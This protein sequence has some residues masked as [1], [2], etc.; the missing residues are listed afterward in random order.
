M[1][2]NWRFVRLS[3]QKRALVFLLVILSFGSSYSL[4]FHGGGFLEFVTNDLLSSD[5][6][7]EDL[8]AVGFHRKLL[9]RFRN[10]YT[11][12]NSFKGRPVAQ[13]TPSSSSPRPI[14]S[15]KA[16]ASPPP[17][18]SP[19]AR[20]VSAPPPF[21]HPLNF[22]ILRKS[23]KPSSNNTVPIVAGCFGGA[24][25]IIL[26]ATGVFF[27]KTK[28][29]KS[30]N[31][32][33]TGLSGQLQKVFITG[34][35]KL[36]RSE[37]EAAC[38]DFSNVIGSCPIGTL[39]K[40][41]L[42][43]GVEIAVA[44]V[45]TAS[46]K[47]W[48]NNIEMQFRKKIEL[49]SKINHKNFV[50]L[51]GYCE[52]DEPFTRILV[53]EYASNGSVF[54]HLHYKES[55]HLDWIMRLRIAMGIAYCL[56]HMHGL[57]PPVVHSSLLSSSVQLTEDY[58]VKIADFN[59]G[60]LKGPSETESSTNALIDTNITETTQEDNVHS[61]GLLLFELMTGKLP[62]SVRKGDSVDTG[63][64]DFLRG[65]TLREMA[66]PTL[67]CFDEKIE[68]IGEVIKSCIRA[69]PKQRLTMKE[70]TGRLREITGLSPDDAIP[71]LSALW[72]AELEVLSTA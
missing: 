70:V 21:V 53:F 6:D 38:E 2:E 42:S 28:A 40:G 64:A 22:P 35:P 61:F 3:L 27:F 56:D 24:V 49:L 54:E 41:T 32:W 55:E 44:S 5:R 9:G 33:R 14:A 72:W 65:K 7:A 57:K 4:K 68:S 17:Q 12:L 11:H 23:S 45:A 25:F 26:L 34:I 67:E 1:S 15:T 52:E 66:D 50:N 63:L 29:G 31:P 13:V 59:F 10:P 39:F 48:T 60:Y 16:S 62:E 19:P 51:L 46:A 58:A 43:T 18:K 47:E 69:D 36:K 30:V 20:H 8:R 71:K 37:I